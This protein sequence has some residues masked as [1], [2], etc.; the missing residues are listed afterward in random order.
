VGTRLIAAA[1]R[2]CRKA[3]CRSVEIDVVNHRGS[4]TRYYAKYGYV[5]AGE[6]P[7]DFD[8]LR[9][10]SHFLVMRKALAPPD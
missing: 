2:R 8:L 6:R 10:P 9:V 5:V 4:L 3:G 1:E 7:F